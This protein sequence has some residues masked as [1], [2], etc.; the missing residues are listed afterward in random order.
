MAALLAETFS[1]SEPP[2]VAVGMSAGELERLVSA[3]RPKALGEQVTIVAREAKTGQVVGA[4]LAEDFETPPPEG[5]GD[6]VPRFAPIGALLEGLD[7]RYRETGTIGRGSHLHLFMLAVAERAAGRG[8]AHRLVET[9]LENGKAR[10]YRFAVTEATGRV[11][12]HVF[13]KLGFRDLFS[14]PYATFRFEG[15][16]PFSSI[17]GHEATIL[18]ER[19]L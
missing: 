9:C 6:A 7:R 1:R 19:P 2:A 17:T 8:I 16:M 4:L 5:L 14:E 10:G 11:S 3:F 18:M 12:Q 15:R 13:R